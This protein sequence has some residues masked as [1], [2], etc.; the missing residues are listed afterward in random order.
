[1]ADPRT[2]RG[3]RGP[4][5]LRPD[6]TS[7]ATPLRRDLVFDDDS[8]RFDGR[9]AASLQAETDTVVGEGV[10]NAASDVAVSGTYYAILRFTTLF[11]EEAGSRL[12]VYEFPL[13]VTVP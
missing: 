3:A 11:R 8:D 1:M 13:D 9:T 2:R 12:R 5:Q 6:W 7:L 10:Q 4:R